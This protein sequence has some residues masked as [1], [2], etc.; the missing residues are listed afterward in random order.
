MT[1]CWFWTGV[2]NGSGYG[3]TWLGGKWVGAH[4][5]AYE[6]LRGPIP[7]H[8]D[9]DHLCRRRLCV[10]PEHLEPVTRRENLRRGKTVVAA[11]LA[12]TRC[13]K[14]HLY[15]WTDNRGARCCKTCRRAQF[16]AFKAR[17]VTHGDK[18]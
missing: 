1:D 6:T 9:I 16:L 12:K 15:D 13:P 2:V 14:G 4:R 5:L 7:A 3:S 10:N 18:A 17:L 11:H 8:Y